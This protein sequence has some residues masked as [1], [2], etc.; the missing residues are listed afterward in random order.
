M[1]IIFAVLGA[2]IGVAIYEWNGF[3]LGIILGYLLGAVLKL[4]GQVAGLLQ[5]M[6][7][8]HLTH[9]APVVGPL[10]ETES[11]P[12]PVSSESLPTQFMVDDAE[13][14]RQAMAGPSVFTVTP[15][16]IFPEPAITATDSLPSEAAPKTTMPPPAFDSRSGEPAVVRYLRDYFTGGNILVRVG[17]IVLFFGVAFLLKY[18][19]ERSQL[20]I[21]FRLMGVA[22]GAMVMLVLGWRLRSRRENYALILQGGGIGVLYLTVFA[23]LRLYHALP[24]GGALGILVA[25][26]VFSAILAI[27]QNSR[28]LAVLGI[29]GGF[30][31]PILTS[32]GSGS[33]VMLFS[34]YAL[35]NAG[36]FGIAWF[37]AWRPLN[38]LG[39]IFTFAIGTLWGVS[40]YNAALFTSTEPFLILFFL[41]YVAIAVLY[42][43]RQS[44]DLKGYVD[45]TLVFGTP[46]IAFGLQAGMV[47]IF[48]YGLA[49]SALAL[50]LFYLLLA[51]ILFNRQRDTFRLLVESFLA[52]GV[53]FGTLAIPLALDGRWTSAVWALEGAAMVWVGARQSRTLARVFGILL[54]F[55]G[56]YAF[57]INFNHSYGQL[58]IFNSVY[59]GS[60]LISFA[61]LFSAWYL[62]RHRASLIAIEHA[63]IHALFAWGVLWWFGAG[64]RE[65]DHNVLREFAVS[66]M[67]VFVA[68]S[69][70]VFSFLNQRLTWPAAKIPALGLLPA[71]V[72]LAIIQYLQVA[73]PFAGL[74]YIGWLLA[75]TAQYWLLR[76]YEGDTSAPLILAFHA[77]ALWLL[78][79]IASWEFAW[80]I[81]HWVQGQS[82]WPLIAWALVPGLMLGWLSTRGQRLAW[83][84]AAHLPTYL[85]L[86]A[87]PLVLFLWLW[88]L[89]TN[90]T[91]DGNPFPII[92]LPLLNPLDLAQILVFIILMTWLIKI[93][94]LKI[95]AFERIPR[96]QAYAVIAATLFIWLNAALLRTLHYWADVPFSI[97]ALMRSV[98]VQA[99]LSIFWSLLALGVMRYA[100]HKKLRLLWFIGAV[101]MAAVVIKLFTIDISGIGSL[102]R[103][104]SF[105]GVAVLML[106][107]GYIA[108]LPERE[109]EVAT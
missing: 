89:F 37:K 20:S 88:S 79:V 81:D 58:P 60:I 87:V 53:V 2:I 104:I 65:I 42:A 93:H 18:A 44:P 90:L 59:I 32:T 57:L 67:L 10:H 77:A 107:V 85:G 43:S 92:Y 103:I 48:E 19:A 64:L 66:V 9:V 108:P 21:E 72:V 70:V 97:D 91:S 54:Q 39:F 24:A 38:L 1:T 36:I 49:Y 8:L 7:Q 29:S 106:V 16:L 15:P 12:Q 105:I 40:K 83:P 98:L 25:V 99:A 41:F 46:I 11:P 31:A 30:L 4:R 26:G 102:A 62:E 100:A 6:R 33:H 86:A 23:A 82:T 45:G 47:R 28:A 80:G 84:V 50:S 74:G 27:V 35:L 71:M 96:T 56:G 55:A 101:L 61:G 34:Y 14:E 17:V 95:G 109:K 13:L 69:S 5:D 94:Q 68:F 63:V 52:L 76:R 51:K 75:F 73:H 78:A 22:V 3:L